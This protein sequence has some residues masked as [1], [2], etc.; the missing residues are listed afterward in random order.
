MGLY[1]D[2]KWADAREGVFCRAAAAGLPVL[3][4]L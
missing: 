3:V 2:G 1:E 4:S